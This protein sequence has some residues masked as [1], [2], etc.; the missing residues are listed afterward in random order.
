MAKP[1]KWKRPRRIFPCS[2]TDMF[3]DFV[4]EPTIDRMFAVMQHAYSRGHQFQVL[5]KRSRRMREYFAAPDLYDRWLAA[6][7]MVRA[8]W[9]DLPC[10][11]LSDPARFPLPHVWLGVSV[12]DQPWAEERIEDLLQTPAA[13]R[14]LS[15]EPALGP[16]KFRQWTRRTGAIDSNRSVI[17]WIVI[18]GESG[19]GARPFDLGWARSVLAECRDTDTACYVKQLGARPF[20]GASPLKLKDRKGGDMEEWPEDLRVRE[21]PAGRIAAAV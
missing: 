18:G 10:V 6:A 12:E 20:D 14:W 11:P 16:V 1:L 7:D 21:Y 9:P 19:P 4:S 13:V 3:A 15:Y 8:A 17:D 2:M 5:T